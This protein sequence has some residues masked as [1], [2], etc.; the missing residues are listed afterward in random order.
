MRLPLRHGRRA[1]QAIGGA[2][3]AATLAALGATAVSTAA[4]TAHAAGAPAVRAAAPSAWTASFDGF[5]ANSWKSA[6]GVVNTAQ[7][8]FD[9]M[10]PL[11]GGG[12][13]VK[14][15]KGSS[16]PSCT[17]CPTGGGAQFYTNLGAIGKG[18]WA[19]GRTLSLKYEIKFPA[20][21]DFGKGAKLP[22]LYGGNPNEA[23]GGTH[24]NGWSTRFMFRNG[25]KGQIYFYSPAGSGYGKDLGLGSWTFPADDQYH[26]IEQYVDRN[27]QT[28]TVWFDGRQVLSTST[29]G[30]S[31]INFGGIFFS[32][33]YGGHSTEWGPKKTSYAW[34]KNFS[35]SQSVQH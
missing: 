2:A 6:W 33:F 27:R 4:T 18:S 23:A 9:R 35:L 34:F 11:T 14:Y 24:G 28:T 29:A 31:G 3:V 19:T 8:G 12:V 7:F 1:R 20:G 10:D 25:N 15:G 16:A 5:P 17:N 30:I 26:T 22:G 32:T 13:K 21:H